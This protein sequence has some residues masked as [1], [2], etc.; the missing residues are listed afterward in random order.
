MSHKGSVALC[1]YTHHAP[2]V[3]TD[4]VRPPGLSLGFALSPL[5]CAVFWWGA[6]S[7]CCSPLRYDRNRSLRHDSVT[8]GIW[9]K[10]FGKQVSLEGFLDED[11]M[12]R[13]PV[14]RVAAG[15]FDPKMTHFL[16]GETDAGDRPIAGAGSRGVAPQHAIVGNQDMISARIVVGIC[17]RIQLDAVERFEALQV[18]LEHLTRLL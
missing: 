4:I 1:R 17:A 9:R 2:V 5:Y 7:G 15:L 18:D 16:H 3:G 13:P 8:R 12:D 6:R 10:R 11:L 14:R